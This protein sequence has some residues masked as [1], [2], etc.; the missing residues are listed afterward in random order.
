MVLDLE[1][2]KQIDFNTPEMI[3]EFE[4]IEKENEELLKRCKRMSWNEF[5]QEIRSMNFI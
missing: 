2:I 1:K 4:Q 5:L 3:A